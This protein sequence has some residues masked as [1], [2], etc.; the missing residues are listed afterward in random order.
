MFVLQR[1]K[2]MKI[3]AHCAELFRCCVLDGWWCSVV[4]VWHWALLSLARVS[5]YGEGGPGGRCP[6]TD[7]GPE[8]PWP[9]LVSRSRRRQHKKLAG[10]AK[11]CVTLI[12]LPINQICPEM[13]GNAWSEFYNLKTLEPKARAELA[14]RKFM[15]GSKGAMGPLCWPRP[16]VSK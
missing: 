5:R 1:S 3:I 15:N 16:D 7:E 12:P 13:L 6:G 10:G 8:S 11:N 2:I 14:R 4:A 9:E